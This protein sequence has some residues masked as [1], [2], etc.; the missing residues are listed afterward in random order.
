MADRFIASGSSRFT[1]NS[2]STW[3]VGTPVWSPDGRS[4]VYSSGQ[5]P[6]ID[7]F[8]KSSDGSKKE[9]LLFGNSTRKWVDDWSS[10]G[11][12]IVYFQAD[13][14]D[15]NYDLWILPMIGDRKPAPL[16]SKLIR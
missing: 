11:R 5:G 4:I 13:P 3:E 2:S 6:Q 1:F 14:T 9:E 8:L 10:D 15:G 12:Y 16:S 7:L